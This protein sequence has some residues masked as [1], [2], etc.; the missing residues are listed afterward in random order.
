MVVQLSNSDASVRIAPELGASLLSYRLND[1]R[2]ILRPTPDATDAFRTACYL[3]VPWCNRIENRIT[4]SDGRSHAIAPT[5]PDHALPIHGSAALSAWSVETATQEIAV[6]STV[7]DWPAPFHYRAEVRYTLNGST[8]RIDLSVTHLGKA[9]LPYGLG[10]HP[11]FVRS[12]ETRLQA[13]ADTW[14]R[15]DARQIP[16]GDE[17]VSNVHGNDFNRFSALPDGVID[18]AFGG[19]DGTAILQIDE[20]LTV[21]ITTDPA[22]RHYQVYSTGADADFVCFE[23]VSHPVNAHNMAGHPGLALLSQGETKTTTVTLTP[24]P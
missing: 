15:T 13:R 3:L 21:R 4:L 24:E 7:C 12:R 17:A 18:T 2:H 5:H 16:V 1:G 10:L 8:L 11:W 14:Q 19:W 20:G 23:P 9:T 6:L 22:L